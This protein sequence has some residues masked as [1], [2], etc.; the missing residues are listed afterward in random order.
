M[1]WRVLVSAPYAMSRLEWYRERLEAGDCEMVVANVRE[2]LDEDELLR[3]VGDID[4][5][6]CGDDR[7]TD[8]VLAAAPRLKVIS[9]WGTG[10][11]SIDQAAAARR[12][13]AVRNTPNAFSEAV[14]DTALGYMLL[15]ARQLQTMTDD[16]RGGRW[17]K[18]QL[19]SLCEW[20]LGVIGVG[21]CGKALVRRAVACG[22]RVL[23]H[24]VV[25]MP[26]EFLAA[27]GLQMVPL[28]ELL[29]RTDVVSIHTTLNPSSLH[30]LNDRTLALMKPTA[31]VIN[32]SR[33][34][35]V[36]E[37]ALVRALEAGRLAGAALDVFE[38]EPLPATSR[39]RQLPNCYL[40]PH[41]ANSSPL[42][43]ERVHENTL[44]NLFAE[45]SSHA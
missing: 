9:K 16:I 37:A 24:D 33:G 15:F 12:R 42:A 43:A 27:S 28:D 20:T 13:V 10:I 44:R 39:L 2:R 7:V 38:V 25:E 14:G 18:P 21:N 4:G 23:G 31:Y 17:E 11:D 45:L 41:N 32:T 29:R 3:I 22:M 34:P 8:R 1:R 6:I 5:M 40:G 36:E 26:A 30:L 35:V 19:I